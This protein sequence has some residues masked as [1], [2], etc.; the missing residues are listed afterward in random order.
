MRSRREG[1]R[2]SL[3]VT[4]D[5]VEESTS[6]SK[7]PN[8]QASH[9]LMRHAVEAARPRHFIVASRSLILLFLFR[10]TIVFWL[11]YFFLIVSDDW[12]FCLDNSLV[13]RRC[14]DSGGYSEMGFI[15]KKRNQ[16]KRNQIG[17]CTWLAIR[18]LLL[19][20]LSLSFLLLISSSFLPAQGVLWPRWMQPWSPW[21]RIFNSTQ[22]LRY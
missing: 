12:C 10:L 4:V 5:L 3:S 17:P 19:F 11:F 15:R 13:A 1:N 9:W 21:S 20:L 2:D 6:R 8:R 22:P 7:Q 16:T 14:D 18:P